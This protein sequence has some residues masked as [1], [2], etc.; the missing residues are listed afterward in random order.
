MDLYYGIIWQSDIYDIRQWFGRDI[1]DY[2]KQ[3]AN[4]HVA[5]S[6]EGEGEGHFTNIFIKP[7]ELET[8]FKYKYIW[9]RLFRKRRR[10]FTL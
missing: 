6:F 2:F 3:M 9:S 4:E 7:I 1:G 10:E 8:T 5:M